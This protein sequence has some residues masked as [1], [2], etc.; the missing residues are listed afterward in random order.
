MLLTYS[1]IVAYTL[2]YVNRI[3]GDFLN[4]IENLRRLMAENGESNYK[5]AKDLGVSQSTI[6]NWLNGSR[7]FA[8]Y[9]KMLADHYGITV[10]ELTG[11]MH[12]VSIPVEKAEK[13]A[14]ALGIPLE[15][16]VAR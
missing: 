7:P 13:A 16:L 6:T 4:F 11:E 3:G 14:A 8:T 1:N 10:E 15:E 12:M 5:L 2:E 9:K